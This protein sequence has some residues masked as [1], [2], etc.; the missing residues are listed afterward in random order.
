MTMGWLKVLSEK[1]IMEERIK[2]ICKKDRT[3]FRRG[4]GFDGITV[5]NPG[6]CGSMLCGP[7]TFRD[8]Q[9]PVTVE[10][11]ESIVNSPKESRGAYAALTNAMKQKD[12]TE[13][14][15]VLLD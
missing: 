9:R 2:S 4:M 8:F 15:K 5:L 1:L 10:D 14:L 11:I 7:V 3:V 12:D 13:I 6:F